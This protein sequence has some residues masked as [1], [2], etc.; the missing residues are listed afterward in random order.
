[1]RNS[2]CILKAIVMPEKGDQVGQ[3]VLGCLTQA[4]QFAA[5]PDEITKHQESNQGY[6]TWG[7]RPATMVTIIGNKIRVVRETLFG[8]YSISMALSFLVVTILMAKG[9]IMG[10]KAIYEYAATA[11]A[12]I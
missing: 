6:R 4:V 5:L 1:M 9:W 2:A 7:A 12:E 8:L 3:H 11:I 10:T